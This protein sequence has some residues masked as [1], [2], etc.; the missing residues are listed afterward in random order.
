MSTDEKRCVEI[1]Q[2]EWGERTTRL[3]AY[4]AAV[5][6]INGRKFNDVIKPVLLF[7]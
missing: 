2:S 5:G 1:S 6:W 3:K 7:N 4:S